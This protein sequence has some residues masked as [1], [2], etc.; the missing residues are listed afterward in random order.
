MID[1]KLEFVRRVS[2]SKVQLSLFKSERVQALLIT[3]A[4]LKVCLLAPF[5]LSCIDKQLA[6]LIYFYFQ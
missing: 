5:K 3:G 6:S 1:L 4:I 2:G